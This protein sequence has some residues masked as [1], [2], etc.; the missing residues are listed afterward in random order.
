MTGKYVVV[1]VLQRN[2]MK[3]N[4]EAVRCGSMSEIVEQNR[5]K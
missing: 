2:E 5:A 4:D 1:Y 3:W